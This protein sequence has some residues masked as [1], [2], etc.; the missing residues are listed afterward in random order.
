MYFLLSFKIVKPFTFLAHS[1]RETHN[2][3]EGVAELIKIVICE[4]YDRSCYMWHVWLMLEVLMQEVLHR[5]ILM[6]QRRSIHI[7]VRYFF[8]AP[9]LLGRCTLTL[10]YL[11]M[12]EDNGFNPDTYVQTIDCMIV[13]TIRNCAY[14]ITGSNIKKEKT[15]LNNLRCKFRFV[16]EF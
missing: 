16:L 5:S 4:Y 2:I 11:S 6:C 15:K 8:S 7:I 1:S 13:Y 9:S 3:T 14:C 12:R 10:Q